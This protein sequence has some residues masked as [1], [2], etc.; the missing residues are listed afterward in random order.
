MEVSGIRNRWL[1]IPETRQRPSNACQQGV[2]S[3]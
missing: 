1:G 2:R 3:L